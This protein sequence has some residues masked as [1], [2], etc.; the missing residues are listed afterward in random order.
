MSRPCLTLGHRSGTIRQP[1]RGRATTKTPSVLL[2]VAAGLSLAAVPTGDP[3]KQ[4]LARLQGT[5]KLISV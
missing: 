2:A 5:W 1:N 3:A 4:D